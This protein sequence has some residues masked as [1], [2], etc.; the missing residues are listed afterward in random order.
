[1]N[2]QKPELSCDLEIWLK[3]LAK[4]SEITWC[5]FIFGCIWQLETTVCHTEYRSVSFLWS[6]VIQQSVA[7]FRNYTIRNAS[8]EGPHTNFQNPDLSC[9]LWNMAEFFGKNWE[10]LP[11]IELCFASQVFNHH[12]FPIYIISFFT[13]VNFS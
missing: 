1:M 11:L 10:K 13:K 12:S 7:K 4:I 3:I 5:Q 9:D 6:L 2:F 8:S